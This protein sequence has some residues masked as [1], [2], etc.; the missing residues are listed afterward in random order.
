VSSARLSFENVVPSPESQV[1]PGPL[2]DPSSLSPQDARSSTRGGSVQDQPLEEPEEEEDARSASDRDGDL[3]DASSAGE[4]VPGTSRP[5][6][7]V[8]L[9]DLQGQDKCRQIHIGKLS[10]GSKGRLCCGRTVTE[11]RQHAKKRLA[12]KDR[13]VPRWHVR[14]KTVRGQSAHGVVG[15][16]CCTQEECDNLLRLELEEMQN[17]AHELEEE[18]DEESR[19]VAGAQTRRSAPVVNFAGGVD[20]FRTPPRF[21]N[22][23]TEEELGDM[24]PEVAVQIAKAV[25][26]E[27]A[28]AAGEDAL[29][30]PG[31][32]RAKAARSRTPA[33]EVL[34]IEDDGS[35]TD[36]PAL[37]VAKAKRHGKVKHAALEWMGLIDPQGNRHVRQE[38]RLGTSLGRGWRVKRCFPD[39]SAARLWLLPSGVSGSD[40]DPSSSSSSSS[41]ESSDVSSSSSSSARAPASA[42]PS[43]AHRSKKKK[44]KKKEKKGKKTGTT[45]GSS[46]YRGTDSSIGDD[47]KIHGFDVSGMEIDS[48]LAPLGLARKDRTPLVDAAVD[49]AALPGVFSATHSQMCDEVQGVTEAATTMLATISGKRAQLHDAQWK[50]QRK[51]SLG[52]VRKEADL[53]A[54]IESVEESSTPA[55]EQQD[56][57]IRMFLLHRRFEEDDILDCLEH[58]LL[59]TI[60]RRSREHFVSLLDRVRSLC[61]H[62]NNAWEGGPAKAMLDHHAKGLGN[63]RA[64]SID[65]R[66][67]VLKTHV[68]LRESADKKF[69]SASMS[70]A[71]WSRVATLEAPHDA[72]TP[73][74]VGA[75]CSHCRNKE[76]HAC[77]GLLPARTNCPF[78]SLKFNSVVLKKAVKQSVEALATHP[79]VEAAKASIAEIVR[80][81]LATP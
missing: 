9:V 47:K 33:R 44:K 22:P 63:V 40:S 24:P 65:Y 58:G 64:F 68:C 54:L 17:I 43:R 62:H 28:K 75:K 4:S 27:L 19:P 52:S 5:V 76:V 11:C 70:E 25:R 55:F 77:L 51:N 14:A 45:S 61:Y 15:E 36:D 60:A 41:S 26:A 71:L 21:P 6:E 66:T 23:P 74:V 72:L 30:A 46:S 10:D 20:V 18:S 35:S 50:T 67:C 42:K 73:P 81:L 56:S 48:A 38:A 53:M 32:G 49:V 7:T 37:R 3:S 12:G 59:P 39:K 13:G 29:R 57:R 78:A 34:N 2:E 1:D 16:N 80:L 31:E 69:F 8:D 79:E